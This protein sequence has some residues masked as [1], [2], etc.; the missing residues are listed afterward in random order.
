[1]SD[2]SLDLKACEAIL[3]R[4]SKSFHF[5]SR[6]LPARLRGPT[7]AVYSFCRVTDTLIDAD[8]ASERDLAAV[9][10]RLDRIYEGRP[11]DDPADRAFAEVVHRFDIPRA[12]PDAL[13][14][15]YAWDLEGRTYERL[16]DVYAYCVRVGSTVGLMMSLLME[17]RAPET[18]ARAADLGIAMQLTNIA[19]DV[20]EDAERERVYLPLAWLEDV[21]IAEWLRHPEATPAVRQAVRRLLAA[22][23][24]AYF[25]AGSGIE[26]LP[27]DCRLAI[28]AALLIYEDIGTEIRSADYD[29]VTRRAY[30]SLP[31]KVTLLYRAVRPAVSRGFLDPSLHG[32]HDGPLPGPEYGDL[33]SAIAAGQV[34]PTA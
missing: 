1:M 4:G 21:A 13:I 32:A 34:S 11:E 8:G 7:A 27:S 2:D 10:R 6:L 31:R 23:D 33:I 22:A 16:P 3:R 14:E 28:R 26:E 25:R 9:V 12:I 15:G 20:G 29:S 24:A 18:L 5:A 19:R 17:V 30:T